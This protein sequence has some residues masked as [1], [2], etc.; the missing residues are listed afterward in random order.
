MKS[1]KIKDG[2][3]SLDSSEQT[4]VLYKTLITDLDERIFFSTHKMGNL[5][6]AGHENEYT[7]SEC[8]KK[9]DKFSSLVESSRI[10]AKAIIMLKA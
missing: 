7:I 2:H 4:L 5:V 6:I 3:K 8:T 9:D 10:W 1:H